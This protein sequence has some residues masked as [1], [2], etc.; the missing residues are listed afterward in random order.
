MS[1]EL[2]ILD[3][4]GGSR[5]EKSEIDSGANQLVAFLTSL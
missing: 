1:V 5:K 4:P 3:K 2:D